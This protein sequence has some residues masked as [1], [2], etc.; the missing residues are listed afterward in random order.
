MASARQIGPTAT[1]PQARGNVRVLSP[2]VTDDEL[3]AMFH[4][5]APQAPA[6]LFDRY[7]ADVNR[8]VWRFLG[9][10]RDHDDLVQQVFMDVLAGVSRVREA[11]GLRGWIVCLTVNKVRTELRK[12]RVRRLFYG[13]SS[14]SVPH[15]EHN[16]DH[17][18]RDSLRRM[19]ALLDQLAANERLAFVLR[20]IEGMPLA[21]AAE[22]CSCSLATIKRHL[23]R[24]ERHFVALAADDPDLS[25][26]LRSGG[27]WGTGEPIA[28]GGES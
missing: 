25:E 12:R 23:Q 14:D 27:R 28:E 22:A 13:G 24:A 2:K 16:D 19:Y 17:E 11:S 6:L 26:R 9:A 5:G 21:Q 4:R 10:D 18:A 1:P 7:E 20:Y 8:L 15:P 3:L